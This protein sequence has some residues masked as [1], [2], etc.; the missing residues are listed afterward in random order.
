MLLGCAPAEVIPSLV[1]LLAM[2]LNV[3]A[4]E[5]RQAYIATTLR[6]ESTLN[7]FVSAVRAAGLSIED[8]TDR[9]QTGSSIRFVDL[10]LLADRSRIW[11]HCIRDLGGASTTC[12]AGVTD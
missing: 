11:V 12:N 1:H 3:P 4:G 5:D 6:N 8:A 10:R 7:S 9:L 2:M